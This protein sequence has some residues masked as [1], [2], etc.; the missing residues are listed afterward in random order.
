[1][2]DLKIQYP[3][4]D[5]NGTEYANLIK[6]YA[7]NENGERFYIKQVETGIEYSEAVDVYPCRYTY[8]A[9]DKKIETVIDEVTD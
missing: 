7:E 5:E 4:T 9:T 1:M 2:I 3:F 8:E 6:H